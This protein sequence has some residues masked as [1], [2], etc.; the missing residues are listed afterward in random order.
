MRKVPPGTQIMFGG[1]DWSGCSTNAT[2][3]SLTHASRYR[4][5]EQTMSAPSA[6]PA[7]AD[8]R[9]HKDDALGPHGSV[10]E[11]DGHS[12]RGI[13]RAFIPA[14]HPDVSGPVDPCSRWLADFIHKIEVPPVL[15]D[16]GRTR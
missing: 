5:S 4:R 10:I 8:R 12:V 15:G 7:L 13:D 2:S 3:L 6:L 16:K 9:H 1:A 14:L 11:L